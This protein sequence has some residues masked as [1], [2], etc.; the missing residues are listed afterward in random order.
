[1]GIKQIRVFATIETMYN[2]TG[3]VFVE[4]ST[5]TANLD[6]LLT[7]AAGY[8]I[9]V[10][11]VMTTG[12]DA[13]APSNYDGG[14]RWDLIQSAPGLT[15][16]QNAFV[17]YISR[18][19]SHSNVIM[20]ETAN[21]PYGNGWN[22][23][24]PAHTGFSA[25]ATSLSVTNTQILAF[26]TQMYNAIKP[27]AGT[28]PVGFSDYEEE[29]QSPWFTLF[30]DS[31]NRPTYI[32]P[33][34]D[35]YSVHIYRALTSELW[36]GYSTLTKPLWIT[37]L[38]SYNSVGNTGGVVQNDQLRDPY[39]NA[40][41]VYALSQ[42]LLTHGAALIMPWSYNDGSIMQ[43]NADGTSTELRLAQWLQGWLDKRPTAATRAIAWTRT[44]VQ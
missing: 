33:A 31:T 6:D 34:T 20:W 16:Y 2:Y 40:Q 13:T 39:Q 18:F 3:G 11:L 21:E 12:N 42:Y 8:N 30:S 23:S 43:Y 24:N 14:F 17:A 41:A 29:E 1:M 27:Y 22:S 5:Y 9:K 44:A 35:V 38:G 37:E 28:T 36:T 32:D 4:N 25:Y 10:I 7:F 26:L 19:N 15:V